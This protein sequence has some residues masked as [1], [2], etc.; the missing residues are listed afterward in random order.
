ML[1]IALSSDVVYTTDETWYDSVWWTDWSNSL[2]QEVVL[3]QME[4]N[5]VVIITTVAIFIMWPF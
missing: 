1:C 3:F 5:F 2:E 4:E